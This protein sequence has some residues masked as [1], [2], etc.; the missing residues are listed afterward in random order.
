MQT[1]TNTKTNTKTKNKQLKLK[2][3]H[4]K[5]INKASP[6]IQAISSGIG[7][8]GKIVSLIE[9]KP[10]ID[11]LSDEGIKPLG[12]NGSLEFRNVKVGFLLPFRTLQFNK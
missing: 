10:P 9:K 7:A 2:L 11:S 3:K 12:I 5:I 1:N 6:S 8:V 4:I